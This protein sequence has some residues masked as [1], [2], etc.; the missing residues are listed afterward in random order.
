MSIRGARGAKRPWIGIGIGTW[1]GLAA[2]ALLVLPS[3]A[4]ADR[5]LR[6]RLSGRNEVPLLVSS[7]SGSFSAK[8]QND[9]T[10]DYEL[11]YEGL[12]G[13]AIFAHIHVGQRFA[14]G[15]VMVFLCNNDPSIPLPSPAC[16]LRGGTVTGTLTAADIIGP[17]GQG[18]NPGDFDA[19][20]EVLQ[21]GRSYV[22]VHST[23]FPSGE[24]RGQVR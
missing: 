19:L 11:R 13:D 10:I 5:S 9:G 6:A 7:A 16:P 4:S 20:L 18:V 2:L 1:T 22:N 24:V 15:G 8:I 12:S 23:V 21:R 14:N 17:A 3:D